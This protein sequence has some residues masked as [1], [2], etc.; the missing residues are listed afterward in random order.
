MS[1]HSVTHDL[2]FIS[3]ALC[4]LQLKSAVEGDRE[5]ACNGIAN[6]VLEEEEAVRIALDEGS[7]RTL[8]GC[9]VDPA[10]AVRVA[11]TGALNN[12]S[13]V[14]PASAFPLLHRHC[15]ATLLNVLQQ[16]PRHT[17]THSLCAITHAR[18]RTHCTRLR[19]V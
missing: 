14:A 9:L 16:V 7:L 12:L 8:V 2:I 17:R 3:C 10:L 5:V 1:V 18:T 13:T 11:A 15:T 4:D 6:L 19:G